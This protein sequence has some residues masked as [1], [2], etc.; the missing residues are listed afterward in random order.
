MIKKLFVLLLFVAAFSGC[1]GTDERKTSQYPRM[2]EAYRN[3]NGYRA[4]GNNI[5]NRNPLGM[6]IY[7]AAE[8]EAEE[9]YFGVEVVPL[10][11]SQKILKERKLKEQQANTGTQ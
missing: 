7:D 9:N 3:D 4:N 10:A 2:P 11:E 5:A 8:L 6:S 1:A